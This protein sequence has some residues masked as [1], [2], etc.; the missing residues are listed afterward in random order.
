MREGVSWV[1]D[2]EGG[3]DHTGG[4]LEGFGDEVCGVCV[5]SGWMVEAEK[6]YLIVARRS[7]SSRKPACRPSGRR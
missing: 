3:P 4:E 6:A 2:V 1:V 7:K 5:N